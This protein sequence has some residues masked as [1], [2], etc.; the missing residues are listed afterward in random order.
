MKSKQLAIV[1]VIAVAVILV[2]AVAYYMDDD[3]EDRDIDGTWVVVDSYGYDT[4]GVLKSYSHEVVGGLVIEGHS[5]NQFYGSYSG[6][7]ITGSFNDSDIYFEYRTSDSTNAMFVGSFVNDTLYLNEFYNSPTES[8]ACHSIL[9]RGGDVPA[10]LEA[11]DM[12][13]TVMKASYARNVNVEG[14]LTDLLGSDPQ[15]L[16]IEKQD[17]MVFYGTM[18]QIIGGVLMNLS[19]VGAVSPYNGGDIILASVIDTVGNWWDLRMTSEWVLMNLSEAEGE[20]TAVQRTYFSGEVDYSILPE[21]PD[22]E[23]TVWRSVVYNEMDV[24][25]NVDNDAVSRIIMA[26]FDYET[27]KVTWEI[28]GRTVPMVMNIYQYGGGFTISEC[29]QWENFN[30]GGG[31]GYLNQDRTEMVIC[32]T[33]YDDDGDGRLHSVYAVYELE[34]SA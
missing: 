27:A 21:L 4:T 3:R 34:T 28:N 26:D 22:I 1:G 24:D 31:I 8:V 33:F 14:T 7:D 9:T 15:Y 5:G 6:I 11:P 10:A 29:Y 25:G 16:H 23:N 20:A 19:I 12:P 30:L 17:K 13:K 18:D 2:V 32:M